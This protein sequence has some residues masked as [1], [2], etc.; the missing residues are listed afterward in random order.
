MVNEGKSNQD[1][2]DALGRQ[3][4]TVKSEL[5]SV[6]TPRRSDPVLLRRFCRH[7]H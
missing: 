3:L 7:G 6:F 5:H 4:N 2:A 1:I